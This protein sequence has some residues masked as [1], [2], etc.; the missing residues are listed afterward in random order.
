LK[1]TISIERTIFMITVDISNVW[2]QLSL[3]DLLSVEAEIAEAHKALLEG[4]RPGSV[5][6]PR[7]SLLE[8]TRPGSDF[9]GWL[10]LPGRVPSS[11]ALWA[12]AISAST[13]SRS[14][15]DS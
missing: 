4:T 9:L 3:P 14:G 11:S 12:S 15:R 8:G 1:Q 10:T 5:S 2:G 7:K 13:L 6:Q